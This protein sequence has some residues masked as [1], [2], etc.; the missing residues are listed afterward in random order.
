MVL[1]VLLL[2]LLC[3]FALVLILLRALHASVRVRLLCLPRRL[4]L[5]T[6]TTSSESSRIFGIGIEAFAV[7]LLW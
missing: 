4:L 5:Q 6:S 1:L 3:L 7:L 2:A